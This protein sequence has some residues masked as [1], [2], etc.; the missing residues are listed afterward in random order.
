MNLC[1]V[2]S[3]DCIQLPVRA[4]LF[5]GAVGL[6][7]RSDVVASILHPLLQRHT[8][9]LLVDGQDVRRDA[10]CGVLRVALGTYCFPVPG[11]DGVP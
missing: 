6:T 3:V 2:V 8:C 9:I 10:C 7:R 11:G 4:V 5:M 1:P